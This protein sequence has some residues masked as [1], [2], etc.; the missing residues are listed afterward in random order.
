MNAVR[1]KANEIMTELGGAVCRPI[2]VRNNDR[3]T[4]IRVNDVTMTKIEGA[5]DK[6]VTIPMS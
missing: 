5:K 3:T 4:T 1:N 2:A 6:I